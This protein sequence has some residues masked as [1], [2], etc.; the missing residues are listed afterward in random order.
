[1]ICLLQYNRCFTFSYIYK[2]QNAKLLNH[3]AGTLQTFYVT[4]HSNYSIL[5]PSNTPNVCGIGVSPY[6]AAIVDIR[7]ASHT[8]YGTVIIKKRFNIAANVFTVAARASE[9][10]N[11]IN[12]WEGAEWGSFSLR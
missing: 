4:V 7:M 5:L 9:R 6:F 8:E 1:M 3:G 10:W 12:T 2:C 11:E